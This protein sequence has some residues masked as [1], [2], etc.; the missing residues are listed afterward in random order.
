[1][2]STQCASS[3]RCSSQPPGRRRTRRQTI[4]EERHWRS[5]RLGE[6]GWY[7][8]GDPARASDWLTDAAEPPA[9]E[10]VAGVYRALRKSREDGKD[11]PGAG[12]FY[13]GEME[14]RR[15]QTRLS[16]GARLRVP[17]RA[18]RALLTLYWALSGYGLRASRSFAALAIV[19]ACFT[20]GFHLYG[21]RDR[22]RPYAARDEL[23]SARPIPFPPPIGD[24]G[25]SWRSFEAWTYS[26]GTATAVVGAPEAQLTQAGR[27]M[28]V[29]LRVIGPIL[30]ALGLLA[31]RGRV[32]R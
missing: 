25:R 23:Q 26:A 12:D 21:F 5:T 15:R 3:V 22:V 6:R 14:M 29:A 27:G 13:Y 19:V 17:A 1:M 7:D 16:S 8:E 20:A 31:V 4:A 11:E 24:L 32:K 9:P 18:E 30:L 28:R 10:Q 2:A